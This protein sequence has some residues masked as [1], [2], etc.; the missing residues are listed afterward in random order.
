MT[1]A[2]V[3]G[4]LLDSLGVTPAMGRVISPSDDLPGVQRVADI[5]YA[6]WKSVFGGDPNI[7][8]RETLYNGVKCNIIGVMKS[9]F[10]FPPGENDAPQV[11]DSASNR[12]RQSRRPRFS[13][14]LHIRAI[15]ERHLRFPGAR[16]AFRAGASLRRK[17][18]SQDA[19]IHT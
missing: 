14:L 18:S 6:T 1:T 10:E 19:R 7:V 15:E 2:L 11:V 5:S 16:R 12:S 9:G 17:E 13:R 3:S 4:G 8:G